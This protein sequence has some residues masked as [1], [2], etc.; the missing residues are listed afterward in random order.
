MTHSDSSPGIKPGTR[1]TSIRV[2]FHWS[3]ADCD[4]P[5]TEPEFSAGV[6]VSIFDWPIHNPLRFMETRPKYKKKK[7]F[8]SFTVNKEDLLFTKNNVT[9]KNVHITINSGSRS[10]NICGATL[11]VPTQTCPGLLDPTQEYFIALLDSRGINKLH[12]KR[13]ADFFHKTINVRAD[14][15]AGQHASL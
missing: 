1:L 13:G 14:K 11:A 15:S 8:R 12:C 3:E 4:R 10:L 6:S 9:R 5:I 2:R 7:L